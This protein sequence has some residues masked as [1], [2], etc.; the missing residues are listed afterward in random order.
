MT[1]P[2]LR[3]VCGDQRH[4]VARVEPKLGDT[5]E[6]L[7]TLAGAAY[8]WR[9]IDACPRGDFD[10]TRAG[11]VASSAAAARVVIARWA[12]VLHA[13]EWY[14][15]TERVPSLLEWVTRSREMTVWVPHP[16]GTTP[17]TYGLLYE[18]FGM[19]WREQTL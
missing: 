16:R 5:E 10:V 8:Y 15:R 3:A 11:C 6:A 14:F 4:L 13:C 12:R 7:A 9:I 17:G 19:V 18:K 1:P 2:E